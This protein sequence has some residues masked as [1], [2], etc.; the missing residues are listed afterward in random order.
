MEDTKEAE[1]AYNKIAKIYHDKRI[2]GKDLNE[3]SEQPAT[4]SLL[5]NIKGK[6]VLDAG[7][8]S[9]V[10]SRLLAEKGAQVYGIELSSEMVDLAKKHCA[11]MD[12]DFKQGSI[13]KLP[14]ANNTF[15]TIIASLVIHYLKNPETALK[16]FHRVLKKGG[17]LI[18]STTH[19]VLESFTKIRNNKGKNEIILS[20][21]FSKGK[22][23]WTLHNSKVK[24]PSYR[25][26]FGLLSRLVYNSGFIVEEIK[27]TSLS[28]KLKDIPS[29]LKKFIDTPIFII[30][31]CKKN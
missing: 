5:G 21:Y 6:K 9:G 18:F 28:N 4:F 31:K 3:L 13:N 27:E 17:I 24:I 20:N 22:Y 7:C 8:G 2:T 14:Y 30:F 29:H 23:Y 25:T 26:G 16:E 15:D 11:G 19:P 1:S 10:Y 12:I